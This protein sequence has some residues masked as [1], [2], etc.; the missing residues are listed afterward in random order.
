MKAPRNAA[1]A[2]PVGAAQAGQAVP[3][4]DSD[5]PEWALSP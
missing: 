2:G 4:D 5:V 3:G 1:A